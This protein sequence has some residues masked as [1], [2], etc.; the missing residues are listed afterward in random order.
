MD[1]QRTISRLTAS[2]VDSRRAVAIR[3][4][5]HVVA[6]LTIIIGAAV[7]LLPLLATLSN[8]FKTPTQ[9]FAVPPKWIP[10]PFILTNY[11]MALT[12][13]PLLLYIGNT[14]QITVVSLIGQVL[15][16]TLAGYAFARLRFPGRDILFTVCLST[17]MLPFAVVL[18]PSYMLFRLLHWIDTYL[19][20]VVPVW[21]GGGAFYIFLARQFFAAIPYDLDEAARV[22]GANGWRIWATIILPLSRPL[23]ATMIIFG[24]IGNWNDFLAPLLYLNSS[25]KYTLALGVA[26]FGANVG[27]FGWGPL[28]A[29]TVLSIAPIGVVFVLAQRYFIEGIVTTGLAAR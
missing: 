16:S 14:L 6:S 26:S 8:S 23:L 19:P 13:V 1:A 22:E 17:L 3:R 10:N 21:F 9:F 20:L 7:M 15:S 12:K 18:I 2:V 24:F 28:M 5:W 25:E 11:E 27:S 29:V 4:A